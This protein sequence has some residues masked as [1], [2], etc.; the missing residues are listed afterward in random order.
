MLK[1]EDVAD[2]LGKKIMETFNKRL[3]HEIDR[4]LAQ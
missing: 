1:D 2:P 3:A 4:I